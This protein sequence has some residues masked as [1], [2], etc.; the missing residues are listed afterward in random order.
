MEVACE[1]EEERMGG[2]T[3]VII[4]MRASSPTKVRGSGCASC[5]K[6]GSTVHVAP[7]TLA[8][9]ESDP[10]QSWVFECVQCVDPEHVKKCA[11]HMV[12][13]AARELAEALL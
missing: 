6:C 7:S 3:M 8:M 2:C 13:G 11:M 12:P 9:I 5:S 4:C 10:A 1:N